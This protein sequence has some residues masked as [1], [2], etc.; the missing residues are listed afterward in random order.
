MR[1]R[2][3]ALAEQPPLVL[4][5]SPA[6]LEIFVTL[7]EDVGEIVEAG[8]FC[9]GFDDRVLE[10]LERLLERWP[11]RLE[12]SEPRL[13]VETS[14]FGFGRLGGRPLESGVE[15]GR[16]G[17]EIVE[18]EP[19]G[20]NLALR[21]GSAHPQLR[22]AR[23]QRGGERASLT[24][25]QAMLG[26]LRV[27]NPQ[28]FFVAAAP[29]AGLRGGAAGAANG[30]LQP[31]LLLPH[32]G[33][34]LAERPHLVRPGALP[35]SQDP[36]VERPET[37]LDAVVLFGAPRLAFERRHLALELPQHVLDTHEVL[38]RPFHLAL[39]R[40]FPAAESGRARRFLDEEP[41]LLGLGVDQLLDA[42]LFD[43]R[44]CLRPDAGPE[45]QLGDVAQPTRDPVD[46]VFGFPRPE[47]APRD[48]DLARLGQCCRQR[49]LDPVARVR[50]PA[51]EIP[52][53]ALEQQRHLGHA[54]RPALAVA[55]EDDVLH[56]LAT[57]MLGALLAQHPADGVDDVRLSAAV[58]AD[59]GRDAERKLEDGPLQER[60]EA[61][62]FDP[63]DPHR[64]PSATPPPAPCSST[65][66]PPR[67]GTASTPCSG[68][69]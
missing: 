54:E 9:R 45:E 19:Q 28:A 62:Q 7:A 3:Q 61:V 21:I 11:F 50:R 22:L 16:L 20:R 67:S 27:A 4:E 17:F 60:F 15:S 32:G 8:L 23:G 39:G 14:A 25:A 38:T 57:E 42:T 47:I 41:D 33:K 26:D 68:A 2:A 30:L 64:P 43:D 31:R 18:T 35:R 53:V 24:G 29:S 49:L 12:R 46:E 36:E 13:G 55:G 56:G 51:L 10:Q 1:V 34:P 52:L 6:S 37:V 48:G 63:L 58:R 65:P 69:G 44:V 59:D 5:L 40:E 66:H